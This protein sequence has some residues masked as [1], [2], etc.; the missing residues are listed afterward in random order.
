MYCSEVH[1]NS[2][3][4]SVGQWACA[5]TAIDGSFPSGVSRPRARLQCLFFFDQPRLHQVCFGPVRPSSQAALRLPCGTQRSLGAT[6]APMTFEL[7]ERQFCNVCSAGASL[8]H[9]AAAIAIGAGAAVTPCLSVSTTFQRP[10]LET[11]T[12]TPGWIG[13]SPLGQSTPAHVRYG[14]RFP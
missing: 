7:W 9:V 8:V 1:I 2:E 5:N 14:A 12:L 13:S 4:A 11:M 3:R 6:P 10:R